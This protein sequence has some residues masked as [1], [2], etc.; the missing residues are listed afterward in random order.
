M[1]AI[2]TRPRRDDLA[3]RRAPRRRALAALGIGAATVALP[4]LAQEYPSRPLRIIVPFTAGGIV[5]ILAR[6]LGARIGPRLGQPVVVENRTGASGSIGT[7]AVARAAPDGHTL[8]LASGVMTI[9]AS[10]RKDLPW[11]PV[12][13]FAAVA[14]LATSPQVIVVNP[15]VPARTLQELIAFARS[16]PG[17]LDFGSVGNGSTPHLTIE[18]LK[19]VTGTSMVHIP[20]RGQPEVLADLAQGSIALTSVTVSL[21]EPMIRAGQLRALAVTTARRAA[22]LPDVPTVA[23]SG[24]SPFDVPNWFGVVAPRGT[25][26]P[27][28]RRLH[29]EIARVVA[30]PDFAARLSQLG[31]EPAAL[32]PEDFARFV[33]ED[34]ARWSGVVARAGLKPE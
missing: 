2:G 29:A 16:N 33:R 15:K 27:V 31:A 14:M 28:V 30:E 5:D 17:R 24:V 32:A 3:R 12:E 22:R 20:Y 8:L 13:S 34:L 4:A 1:E 9:S 26:E 11:H 19:S 23:E 7:E 10:M 6:E 21:A 18:L 25:P